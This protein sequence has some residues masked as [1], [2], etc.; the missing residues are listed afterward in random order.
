MA[1]SLPRTTAVTPHAHGWLPR[2]VGCLIGGN[3]LAL[4][5]LLVSG[6]WD[7]VSHAQGGVDTFWY[8]P[9]YGI[10]GGL[11]F[12][13]ICAIVGW[14]LALG[15]GGA[16]QTRRMLWAMTVASTVLVTGAPAD[17]T[18]H[19]VFG[20]DLSAWSPPHMHLAIGTILVAQ[21]C[22][23]GLVRHPARWMRWAGVLALAL[24]WSLATRL[25]FE[26]ENGIVAPGRYPMWAWPVTQTVFLSAWT[27]LLLT[28]GGLALLLRVAVI[29]TALRLAL[30]IGLDQTLLAYHGAAFGTPPLLTVGAG[31]AGHWLGQRLP[32][33]W[34]VWQR[35]LV[36]TLGMVAAVMALSIAWWAVFPVVPAVTL[37]PWATWWPV[38]LGSGLMSAV[39]MRGGGQWLWRWL[40]G[41]APEALA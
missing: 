3:I 4:A 41:S 27:T 15:S 17:V 8:P 36:A 13:F 14:L 23:A 30:W 34:T 16:P 37:A 31:M 20:L 10:Y 7:A 35:W 19:L 6:E 9:H 5:A 29:A 38:A 25:W 26:Y 40:H 12:G 2:V 39:I 28:W 33:A 24:G 11:A 1:Q 21:V 22:G 18:W 32:Q